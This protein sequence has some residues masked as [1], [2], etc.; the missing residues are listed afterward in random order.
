MLFESVNAIVAIIM[1]PYM[2]HREFTDASE[3]SLA[4]PIKNKGGQN[5]FQ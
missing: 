1:S 3:G 2:Q 4:D 5:E